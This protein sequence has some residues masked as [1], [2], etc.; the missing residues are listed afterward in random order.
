MKERCPIC[1]K[2]RQDYFNYCPK[3]GFHFEPFPR[4]NGPAHYLKCRDC[5][6]LVS[7]RKSYSWGT[8]RNIDECQCP[9]LSNRPRIMY[10]SSKACKKGFEPKE[11]E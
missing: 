7:I 4:K 1:H 2:I 10:A 9:S 11:T 6:Y 5:K 8:E 3:C